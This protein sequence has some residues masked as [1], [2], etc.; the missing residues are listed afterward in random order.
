MSVSPPTRTGEDLGLHS[1]CL[2]LR[3]PRVDIFVIYFAGRQVLVPPASV[4]IRV[5]AMFPPTPDQP[6]D[7][8]IEALHCDNN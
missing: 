8:R 4:P 3:Q 7:V 6:R 5:G 2:V 1:Q